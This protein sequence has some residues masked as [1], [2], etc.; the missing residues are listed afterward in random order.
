M[1]VKDVVLM[2]PNREAVIMTTQII[3]SFDLIDAKRGCAVFSHDS[4]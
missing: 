1:M 2:Y 3:V 4:I